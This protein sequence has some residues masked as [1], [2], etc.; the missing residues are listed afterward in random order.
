MRCK[1]SSACATAL[2]RRSQ[3]AEPRPWVLDRDRKG[4]P[5]ASKGLRP[6]DGVFV[7]RTKNRT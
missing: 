5:S 3:K 1:A 2:Q 6:A 4:Q 7:R